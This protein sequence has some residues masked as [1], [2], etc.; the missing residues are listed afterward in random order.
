VC[1]RR[2]LQA[3]LKRVRQNRGEWLPTIS[4]SQPAPRA[5]VPTDTPQIALLSLALLLPRA[6][7]AVAIAFQEPKEGLARGSDRRAGLC[8]GF[9]QSLTV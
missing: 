4:T 6:P 3:A 7:G 5:Y 2:N 1:E 9:T 8:P